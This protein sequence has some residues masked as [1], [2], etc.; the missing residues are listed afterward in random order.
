M[1]RKDMDELFFH[2]SAKKFLEE[3]EKTTL[4]DAKAK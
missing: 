1:N 4:P 2:P 3:A